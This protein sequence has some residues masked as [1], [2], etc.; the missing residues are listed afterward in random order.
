MGNAPPNPNCHPWCEFCQ[1]N[2]CQMVV[3]IARDE[4]PFRHNCTFGPQR[5][6]ETTA[7]EVSE[8]GYRFGSILPHQLS[9][10]SVCR[11]TL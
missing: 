1:P 4:T 2:F 8:N 7:L 6:E 5:L 11:E 9:L 3:V 10:T